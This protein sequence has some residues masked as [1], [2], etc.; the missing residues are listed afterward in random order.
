MTTATKPEQEIHDED[1]TDKNARISDVTNFVEDEERDLSTEVRKRFAGFGGM[2]NRLIERYE[3]ILLPLLK[4]YRGSEV[5][6]RYRVGV[7]VVDIKDNNHA[8]GRSDVRQL[9]GALECS[10]SNLYDY[11]RVARAWEHQ[12]FSELMD[13]RCKTKDK[14][15]TF[16]HLIELSSVSDLKDRQRW[17]NI[18]LEH[19][20]T[21]K[22][23]VSEIKKVAE[24]VP[25]VLGSVRKPYFT[26]KRR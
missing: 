20:W 1:R 9:A 26:A 4:R 19:G 10:P 13:R 22:K 2:S 5:E 11:A 15:L 7:V 16:S 12:A 3:E 24:E 18:A 8:Y 14:T 6:Y 17:I 23:L 21:V 25:A